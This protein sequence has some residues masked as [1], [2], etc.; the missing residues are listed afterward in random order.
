MIQVLSSTVGVGE[1]TGIDAVEQQRVSYISP[2]TPQKL[3]PVSKYEETSIR[4][5]HER[6]PPSS[7]FGIKSLPAVAP[8]G[9][10]MQGSSVSVGQHETG[11]LRL[12]VAAK[13]LY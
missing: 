5:E 1:G 3:D 11:I 7:P 4:S 2:C 6:V 12:I 10:M 13:L 8:F 9:Q